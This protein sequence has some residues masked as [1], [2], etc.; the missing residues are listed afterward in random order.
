MAVISM[1]KLLTLAPQG[2][3]VDIT[4]IACGASPRLG[5]PLKVARPPG[6][7]MAALAT[8]WRR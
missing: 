5:G 4:Y 8:F 2:D 3:T 1:P 6:S 7:P